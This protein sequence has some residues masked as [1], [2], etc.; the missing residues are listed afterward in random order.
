MYDFNVEWEEGNLA[1]LE[2]AL[3]E[4]GLK[5][6]MENCKMKMVVIRPANESE[7]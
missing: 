2:E 3:A 4:L 7:G 6:I 5:L 1:S